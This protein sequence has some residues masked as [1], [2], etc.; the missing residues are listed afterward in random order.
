MT[1]GAI[2]L[3][4]GDS[5]DLPSHIAAILGRLEQEEDPDRDTRAVASAIVALRAADALIVGPLS[6][7]DA[8]TPGLLPHLA[9]LAGRGYRALRP[10][11]EIIAHPGFAQIAQRFAFIQMSHREARALGAGAVDI[12]ILAQRLRQVQGDHGEF[13]ITAF[14]GH[15]LLWADRRWWEIDPVGDDEV[16]ERRAG[17]VFCTAWVVA[18]RFLRAP[19]SMALAYARSAVSTAVSSTCKN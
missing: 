5:S 1:A 18:R 2:G 7:D 12:G 17:A 6:P 9:D 15:G 16:D 10:P 11:R 14:G 3:A 8:N 4:P 13:A 19:A